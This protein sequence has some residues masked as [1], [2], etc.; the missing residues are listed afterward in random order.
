MN[1]TTRWEVR[2]KI[3]RAIQLLQEAEARLDF[4]HHFGFAEDLGELVVH[5]SMIVGELDDGKQR[6]RA[7]TNTSSLAGSRRS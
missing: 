1:N 5:L 7:K 2:M 6:R 3:L 4:A